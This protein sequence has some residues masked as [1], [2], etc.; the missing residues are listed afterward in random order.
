MP[1]YSA[2]LPSH[3]YVQRRVSTEGVRSFKCP[4]HT[5]YNCFEFYGAK[6]AFDLVKCI[7]CPRA[8]HANCVIPGSRFNSRC[9]VCPL[10]PT[11]PLPSTEVTHKEVNNEFS[12]FWEQLAI[13]DVVPDAEDPFDN[14]F[15]L[16]RHIKESYNEQPLTFKMIHKNDYEFMIANNRTAPP[17]FVPEV[18]CECTVVCD[19]HCLNRILR[20][21]CCDITSKRGRS[22]E[23]DSS[24]I[25]ALGAG[26][27]NRAIQQRKYAKTEAFREFQMGWGLRAKESIPGGGLVMEYVGEV[28]DFAEVHRRMTSQRE[29]RVPCL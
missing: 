12:L 25:C 20:I 24:S 5:C 28:I 15:K 14:H 9:V 3:H 29:V 1:D 10:H 8:L 26:C 4:H 6:D 13:P 2:L 21:E 17:G 18:A 27:T 11:S 16:Q 19:D 22:S 7:Y 23:C